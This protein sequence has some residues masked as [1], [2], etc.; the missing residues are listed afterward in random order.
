MSTDPIPDALVIGAGP[1][2]L[3]ASWRLAAQGA[4][5]ILLDD[6]ARPAAWVAAGMLAPWSEVGDSLDEPEVHRLRVAGARRW[7]R[8][9]ADLAEASGLDPG[10][11]ACGSLVVAARPEHLAAVRRLGE[12]LTGLGRPVRWVPGS[13]LREIEPS[14][15]PCVA[16]GLD[17]PD[18]AA[19][20]PRLAMTALRVAC[21]GG[22]VE[23]RR[24]RAVRITRGRGGRACGVALEDRSTLAAGTVVLAAGWASGRLARRVPLRPVKGQILHLGAL[25]RRPAPIARVVRT[26]DVYLVPRPDGRVVVGATMEEAGDLTV[27]AGAVHELLDE[28]LRVVP[29]LAELPLGEALSGLRPATP[30]GAPALGE[31]PADGIVWAVGGGRNG[32]LLAPLV[33]DAVAAVVSGVRPAPEWAPFSP[34]RFASTGPAAP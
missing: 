17:Q 18:E 26:P 9:A 31:D 20:D 19:V 3:A 2:G 29:D 23:V 6:G 32:V 13:G 10:L 33:G 11:S 14:L 34:A 12:M 16:G 28:A 27:T 21:D 4:R 25:A 1:W 5:V 30:D 24:E 15:A 22:G 8:F 7:P